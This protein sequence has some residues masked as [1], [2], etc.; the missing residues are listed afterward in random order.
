[1]QFP[2]WSCKELGRNVHELEFN[3]KGKGDMAYVLLRS[4][5]HHDNPSSLNDLEKEHLEKGK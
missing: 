2:A 4:D 5:A 3:F 1:M